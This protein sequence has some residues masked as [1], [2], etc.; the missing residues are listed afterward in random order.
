MDP[1]HGAAEFLI[2]GAA[3]PSFVR[4]GLQRTVRQFGEPV[5]L[6]VTI[7]RLVSLISVENC[8]RDPPQLSRPL[9]AGHEW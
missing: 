3:H 8:A 9:C 2:A 1:S 4:R 5:R 7:I 6:R